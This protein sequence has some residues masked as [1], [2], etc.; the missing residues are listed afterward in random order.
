MLGLQLKSGIR[1]CVP[2]PQTPLRGAANRATKG[3]W[4]CRSKSS[5]TFF[6]IILLGKRLTRTGDTRQ[7][8]CKRLWESGESQGKE[9][10]CTLLSRLI[11]LSGDVASR[12]FQKQ[13]IT[14]L[15]QRKTGRQNQI[16]LQSE[17]KVETRLR[18]RVLAQHTRGPGFA[19]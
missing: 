18:C 16:N 8:Q 19:L 4:N 12:S 15:F 11:V 1:A 5:Q 10:T 14:S 17:G 7:E 3:C 9:D 2:K 6:P 13:D